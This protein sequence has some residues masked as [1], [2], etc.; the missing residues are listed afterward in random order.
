[1]IT[2]LS[3]GVPGAALLGSLFWCPARACATLLLVLWTVAIGI[4]VY[5]DLADRFLWIPVLLALVGVLGLVFVL[6]IPVNLIL[7]A[8]E[9]TFTMFI[10]SLEVLTKKRR[11]FLTSIRHRDS[12]KNLP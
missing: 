6:A 3:I 11:L 2:L 1:M 10:V 4:F 7:A 9:A 8:N 5:L 12:M